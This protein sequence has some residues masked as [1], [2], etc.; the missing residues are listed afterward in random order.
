MP[1]FDVCVHVVRGGY[2]SGVAT[3]PE[4][5]VGGEPVP[6]LRYSKAVNRNLKLGITLVSRERNITIIEHNISIIKYHNSFS[7]SSISHRASTPHKCDSVRF[8]YALSTQSSPMIRAAQRASYCLARN[9]F[10]SFQIIR[11]VSQAR[12]MRPMRQSKLHNPMSNAGCTNK[13]F[14]PSR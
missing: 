12:P 7:P 1:R 4:K 14:W 2:G 9:S 11:F 13:I 5:P 8:A 10:F 6:S 3:V